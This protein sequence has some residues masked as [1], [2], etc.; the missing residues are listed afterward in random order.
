MSTKRNLERNYEELEAP[1]KRAR[2]GQKVP[3]D[4]DKDRGTAAHE[5]P[6]EGSTIPADA[7]LINRT[8]E[9]FNIHPGVSAQDL[10]VRTK[11]SI[12][13]CQEL[14]SVDAVKE[15]P[16]SAS[17]VFADTGAAN[18]AVAL[19]NGMVLRAH[20]QRRVAQQAEVDAAVAATQ[21]EMETAN[22]ATETDPAVPPQYQLITELNW[23]LN[24][25]V[26]VTASG[27]RTVT[28]T[29]L[30][31]GLHVSDIIFGNGLRAR[32]AKTVRV[33]YG[34]FDSNGGL[35]ELAGTITPCIFRI[36]QQT[37]SVNRAVWITVRNAHVGDLRRATL[38]PGWDQGSGPQF[39]DGS[40][41]VVKLLQVI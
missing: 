20:K 33:A 6:D 16:K 10:C 40:V 26:A 1:H 31:G 18:A 24:A 30:F 21:T 19:Y 23:G 29:T 14:G 39:P 3:G 34:L 32:P 36:E 9:I 25:P 4:S 27:N 17:I 41:L 7:E 5:V 28:N 35:L 37:T 22:A 2:G 11:I 38:T 12:A 13:S 15:N 8:V